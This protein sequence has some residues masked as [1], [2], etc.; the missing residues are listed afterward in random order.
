MEVGLR[1][2]GPRLSVIA[3]PAGSSGLDLK[4]RCCP[5]QGFPIAD[6]YLKCN[7]KLVGEEEELHH[8]AI[9]SLEPRLVGGK[10]GFGSMLRALGAQIEK[11]TN[12]EAC[13]D[14][15]GRRLRD[16]NHEKAMAE[17]IKKQAER[18]VEKEQR[19]MDRLQRKLA[20]PK[21]YFTDPQ[22]EQ[23]LDEMS[24][25][26]EDSVLK[27]L[28]ASSSDVVSA[29]GGAV[30]KRARPASNA[31]AKEGKKKCLWMGV[32]SFE[33]SA[34]S[35]EESTADSSSSD[36]SPS[37]SES[38]VGQASVE[39][40]SADDTR[41]SAAGPSAGSCA[42]GPSAGSCAAGPSAGSCAAGPSAGSC[43]AGPS[44]GS[45]AAGPSAGSCAAGPSAGSCAAGPSAGSCAAGPSAGSCAAG[46]SAGS[47][48][49]GPSAGSCAAGP[50]AGSCAAGPSAGSCAAGPSAGSCAAGPSAGSCA[51]G[52]SAGSCAA[53]PSAGSCAAGPSAGSC[54]AGPAS[55]QQ[56]DL[57]RAELGP[58]SEVEVTASGSQDSDRL[59]TEEG[60]RESPEE[61]E[62]DKTADAEQNVNA[63]K[64]LEPALKNWTAF[65]SVEELESLGLDRL[66]SELM[67]LGLKCGGTLQE[68]AARLFS[69]KGLSKEQID[70][71]FF[72]K[73]AKGKKK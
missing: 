3:L 59:E 6:V 52:P 41:D 17:W 72:A 14:L 57:N 2:C 56:E 61:M 44:A 46:P 70:P 66:K 7:G 11:T 69:V 19:R 27:G 47:C 37:H 30:R 38:S 15:S 43:A 34:S 64:T 63:P 36:E 5:Q 48:A 24:E 35:D 58:S 45:C 51:A 9:Y 65:N 26:L 71:A 67:A 28:Q 50:S 68:R 12:R 32:E 40:S 25:R 18:E 39:S 54:A 16:V 20:E 42:A 62:K 33:E 13:R 8:G 22:Y 55:V 73:P 1:G 23:Q 53:G 31:E 60:V 49:A 10:G 21:H 4:Q 29:E